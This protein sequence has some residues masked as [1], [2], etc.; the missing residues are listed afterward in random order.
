MKDNNK[1][2]FFY[3][4][5]EAKRLVSPSGNLLYLSEF[6]SKLYG[7]NSPDSDSDYKGV[8]LPNKTDLLLGIHKKDVHFTTGEQNS[9]NNKDDIDIQLWSLQYFL[10]LIGKG[11]TN[12][13]DLLFSIYSKHNDKYFESELFQEIFT[14]CVPMELIDV[15]NTKSY[16]SYA[17]H[18][19][20][21]YGL[22]G[23][24]LGKLKDIINY[25]V[26]KKYSETVKMKDIAE[27]LLQKFY[28]ESLCFKKNIDDKELLYILGK[29]YDYHI[30]VSEAVK[31]L[32]DDYDKY[33]ERAKQA[34][35]NEGIDWKAVSHA[36]RC[37]Y[38]MIEL[39]DIGTVLYPL[40]QAEYLKEIKYGKRNWKDVEEEIVN[41]LHIVDQKV[42]KVPENKDYKKLHERIILEHY[43][44]DPFNKMHES[45]PLL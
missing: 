43:K 24:R 28:D 3:I 22:K 41:L 19:A 1:N 2:N 38:Q 5:N 7:T 9:K 36:V 18:Q 14:D 45:P 6:G 15:R 35:L 11:D 13:L 12:A 21:K 20:K 30:K 32:R 44:T 34:E 29:G 4:V 10:E 16:V 8:F 42:V 17:Y 23:S 26:E 27:D 25:F 39:I 37:L 33:G 31:R 40:Q